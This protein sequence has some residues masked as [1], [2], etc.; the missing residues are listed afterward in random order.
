MFVGTKLNIH[1]FINQFLGTGFLLCFTQKNENKLTLISELIIKLIH[2]R[3][4][5]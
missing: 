1:E 4:S 5:Y 3:D 2:M